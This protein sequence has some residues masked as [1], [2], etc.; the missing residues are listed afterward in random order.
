MTRALLTPQEVEH[1]LLAV[2]EWDADEELQRISRTFTFENFSDAMVFV[3]R[4]AEIA[5]EENHH[6][7][8]EIVY[9]KVTLSLST[10]SAQGLTVKDFALAAKIDALV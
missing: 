1:H 3:N 10:H 6:P 7:D 9:N 5:E 4:A 8:I 2:P